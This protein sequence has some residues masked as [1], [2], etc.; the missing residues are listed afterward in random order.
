MIRE[1]KE[2]HES[3]VDVDGSHLYRKYQQLV[4][5]G[6]TVAPISHPPPPLSGWE[7]VTAN[8]RM[9]YAQKIPLV[10]QGRCVL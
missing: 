3:V 8:N 10:T 4:D 1:A 9:E 7:S 5:S 6:A 2:N